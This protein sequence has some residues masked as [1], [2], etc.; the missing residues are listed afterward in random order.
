MA[1]INGI[2]HIAVRPTVENYPRTVEF[3]TKILG[4]EVVQSWGHE[5]HPCLMVSCG[6]NSCMEILPQVET[7]DAP[8]GP[9]AH[10]AF[11]SDDV[12]GVVEAVRAAGYAV[13]S[14]PRDGELCGKQIRNAFLI[15]PVGEIIEPFQV[16]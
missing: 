3:Y 12:D 1:L 10:I 16:K 5:E 6:D 14:E 7:P 15:G 8:G 9:L 11:W 13:T 2:H 4:M